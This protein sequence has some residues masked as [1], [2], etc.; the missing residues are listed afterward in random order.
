MRRAGRLR[1]VQLHAHGC[2]APS[3]SSASG[4]YMPPSCH[5]HATILSPLPLSSKRISLQFLD[6]CMRLAKNVS[7]LSVKNAW[8]W[9]WQQCRIYCILLLKGTCPACLQQSWTSFLLAKKTV[10][11]GGFLCAVSHPVGSKHKH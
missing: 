8:L 10:A 7:K 6:I 1:F 11:E 9:R 4:S 2:S 3:E 5:H